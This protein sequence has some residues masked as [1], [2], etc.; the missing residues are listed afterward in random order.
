VDRPTQ[1]PAVLVECAFIMLP[2]QE[3]LL[4]TE[5]FQNKLASSIRRGIEKFLREYER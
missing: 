2:E 1:Y 3:A 4:K 5:Q